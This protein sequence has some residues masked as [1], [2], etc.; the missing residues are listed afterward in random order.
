LE[1]RHYVRISFM[2]TN[3]SFH[4]LKIKRFRLATY[5]FAFVLNPYSAH[6]LLT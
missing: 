5:F 4:R 2:P 6:R 3:S 1:Q